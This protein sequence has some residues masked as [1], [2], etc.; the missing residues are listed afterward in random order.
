[1]KKLRYDSGA[2][3]AL[4]VLAIV[5][6]VSGSSHA[7][8][9]YWL[10]TL[11]GNESVA[12]GVSDDGTVVG[13]ARDANGQQRAFRWKCGGPM[14][15]LGTLGGPESIA[16]DIS[17]DGSVI[18]GTSRIGNPA[19][20]WQAFKYQSG[21]MT[22]LGSLVPL[23]TSVA[24]SVSANGSVIVGYSTASCPG[25]EYDNNLGDCVATTFL[26]TAACKWTSSGI[27]QVGNCYR[28][29]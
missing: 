8:T 24:R 25:Y 13:W 15:D 11:G 14:V 7:Q 18:V 20:L 28:D 16:N 5:L 2:A 21:V 19:T 6:S 3:K 12:L 9:L 4:G 23:G 29:R 22:N 1:M 17:A 26:L 10:G 27:S